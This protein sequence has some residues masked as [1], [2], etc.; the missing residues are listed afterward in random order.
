MYPSSSFSSF[1]HHTFAPQPQNF[2][3]HTHRLASKPS[4]T[5]FA[6]QQ[7]FA[8]HPPSASVA[9]HAY[10]SSSV[11]PRSGLQPLSNQSMSY[12]PPSVIQQPPIQNPF[13][14]YL[15]RPQQ[16][17]A[18]PP[19]LYVSP[20]LLKKKSGAREESE[21]IRQKHLEPPPIFQVPEDPAVDRANIESLMSIYGKKKPLPPDA[22]PSVSDSRA[23]KY[24]RERKRERE[25]SK[26]AD[27]ERELASH[28]I[29]TEQERCDQQL[30]QIEQ[31]LNDARH[32]V[33][34]GNRFPYN[35]FEKQQQQYQPFSS[36]NEFESRLLRA[37]GTVGLLLKRYH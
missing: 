6:N 12:I 22:I 18:G 37:H 36:F 20:Y 15:N 17:P 21:R 13:E 30:M 7:Q 29:P 32:G 33:R 28:R 14:R 1:P 27:F 4:F 19:T 8:S 11:A 2:G 10:R 26:V 9:G 3:S 23:S 34:A 24:L 25:A 31:Q 5:S 35:E 16:P